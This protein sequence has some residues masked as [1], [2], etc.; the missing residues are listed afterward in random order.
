[1]AETHVSDITELLERGEPVSIPVPK[2]L[3]M[4][5][6]LQ[7]SMAFVAVIG[8]ALE[9]SGH[10]IASHMQSIASVSLPETL[11]LSEAEAAAAFETAKH[12]FNI[13][14]QDGWYMVTKKIHSSRGETIGHKATCIHEAPVSADE[15]WVASMETVP[16]GVATVIKPVFELNT[17]LSEGAATE[18][19]EPGDVATS[20]F[21]DAQFNI[22]YDGKFLFASHGLDDE[23]DLPGGEVRQKLHAICCDDEG[24]NVQGEESILHEDSM[25]VWRLEPVIGS[26]A[27]DSWIFKS[28]Q[29]EWVG[30]RGPQ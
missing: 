6:I 23:A 18:D 30:N 20:K 7:V 24:V 3:R 13:V 2:S 4:S 25:C 17:C 9:C 22:Q 8:A 21:A 28:R 11:E 29:K 14:N 26:F 19:G 1:M 15:S 12:T 5:R 10:G 16:T 27:R